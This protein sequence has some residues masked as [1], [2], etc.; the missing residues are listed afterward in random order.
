MTNEITDGFFLQLIGNKW[1]TKEDNNEYIFLPDSL[2]RK[3]NPEPELYFQDIKTNKSYLTKYLLSEENKSCFL[4]FLDK[5]FKILHINN[6]TN[7]HIMKLEN[8]DDGNVIV[9][10]SQPLIRI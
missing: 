6:S 8:V 7:P 10:E 5:K 2:N 3:E 9:Y 1:K 4:S